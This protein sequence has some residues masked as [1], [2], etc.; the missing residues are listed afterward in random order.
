MTITNYSLNIYKEINKMT[1]YNNYKQSLLL[2]DFPKLMRLKNKQNHVVN[3]LLDS[4]DYGLLGEEC[5][6]L[7]LIERELTDTINRELIEFKQMT[8][9][10]IIKSAN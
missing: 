8:K 7:K 1:N 4:E 3:A 5:V 10:K 9:A 6:K 2:L